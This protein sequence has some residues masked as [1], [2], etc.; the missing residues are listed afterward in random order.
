MNEY[1]IKISDI[2]P[3]QR[4][5]YGETWQA[6]S[7]SC[8]YFIKIIY[9][10]FHKDEYINSFPVVEYLNQQ[11]IDFISKIVKT[12]DGRLFTTFNNGVL[13]VFDWINGKVAADKPDVIKKNE[14]LA[15][16]YSVPDFKGYIRKENFSGESGKVFFDNI[17][18]IKDD[19]L[20]QS[21]DEN[22]CWLEFQYENLKKY[23]SICRKDFSEFHITHGDLEK[24]VLLSEKK[25]FIIDWD[26]PMLAPPER[27]AWFCLSGWS[28]DSFNQFLRKYNINYSLK[29]ERLLYYNYYS[30]FYYMT[31]FIDEY[32]EKGNVSDL[33]S[34]LS[35][36]FEK[37]Q[38]SIMQY[39]GEY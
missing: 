34:N 4:G 16:I 6:V 17:Q 5:F 3:A 35:A 8:S 39:V 32:F 20:K 11:G 24:N 10:D 25:Y 37:W 14:M 13:G 9:L 2:I 15:K 38:N 28:K 27:D 12:L 29:E 31:E 19:E 18:K 7:G 33:V 30:F 26:S 36:F 1:G 21:L 23:S 22:W